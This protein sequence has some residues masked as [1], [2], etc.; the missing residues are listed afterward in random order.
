MVDIVSTGYLKDV[1]IGAMASRDSEM[2]ISMKNA[3]IIGKRREMKIKYS[4]NH[5]NV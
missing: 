1:K 2:G 5:E 3:M 4:I